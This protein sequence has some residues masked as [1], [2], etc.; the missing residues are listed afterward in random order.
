M[1]EDVAGTLQK[2]ADIGFTQVEPYNFADV[3]GLAEA[4]AASGL[5]APTTHAHYL[6]ESDDEHRRIF[7]AAKS[8]GIPVVIDPH[9]AAERWQTSESIDQ[10]AAELNHA[11]EL[12][13]EYGVTVGY[14][15]HA[16]EI[17]AKVGDTT[18]IEYFATKLDAGIVLEIDTYWVTVGG[19]DPVELLGKLGDTVV[20][21]HVKDGP[22]SGDTKDQ[23]AVGAGSLPIAAILRA[24]PNAL[25]VVELDDSRGDRVQAV[26]DSFAFLTSEGLA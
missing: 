26:A 10:V 25:K 11:G 18:A 15:N 4:M 1:A 9:A 20:A 8:M 7:S 16:H 22:G 6:G 2:I 14:H 23:V 5:T 13:A 12:A 17:Q 21:I 3:P 24:A 19:G